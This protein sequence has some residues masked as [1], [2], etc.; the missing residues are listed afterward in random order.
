MKTF[1][2]ELSFGGEHKTDSPEAQPK[3]RHKRK[4]KTSSKS[5]SKSNSRSKGKQ[6]QSPPQDAFTTPE[7]PFH[8]RSVSTH[9]TDS[10][11]SYHTADTY[12]RVNRNDNESIAPQQTFFHTGTIKY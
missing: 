7:R 12:D 11:D 8:D 10:G 2:D 1:L 3:T 4:T 9:S 5:G 6:T